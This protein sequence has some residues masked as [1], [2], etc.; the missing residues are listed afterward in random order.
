MTNLAFD[1]MLF[2]LRAHKD[3]RRK[4]TNAPYAGHLAEVAGIASTVSGSADYGA[5]PDEMI[6]VAWLHD[7]IEDRGVTA[8]QLAERFGETVAS[9]VL[10]LSDIEPGIRAE[11]KAVSRARLE[12]A[13]SWIQTIKCADII[14]N[15]STIRQLDPDFATTYLAE[16]R[17]L[18]AV[19]TKADRRLW[20]MA[21]ELANQEVP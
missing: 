21:N 19:L 4:Y 13:A 14:S 18:L 2:A 3:H 10:A 5:S 6:A 8:R 9:G 11:R 15:V 20:T 12:A 16:K 7:V 17:A 1:A